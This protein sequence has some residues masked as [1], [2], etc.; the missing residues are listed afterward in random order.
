[1]VKFCNS[2]RNILTF[3]PIGYYACDHCELKFT[4]DSDDTLLIESKIIDSNES[5]ASYLNIAYHDPAIKIIEEECKTCGEN[6]KVA[7]LGTN[8]NTRK[9]CK[10][11]EKQNIT[12][13]YSISNDNSGIQIVD[14]AATTTQKR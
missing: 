3:V 5:F 4:M 13:L 2:C 8:L 12:K 6:Y 7:H 11:T 14:S 10:C 9:L 1:M